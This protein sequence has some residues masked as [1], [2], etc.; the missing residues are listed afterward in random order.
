MPLGKSLF[1]GVVTTLPIGSDVSPD[2]DF[3]FCSCMEGVSSCQGWMADDSFLNG[4]NVGAHNNVIPK[5]V[6]NF[7]DNKIGRRRRSLSEE[8]LMTDDVD[9]EYDGRAFNYSSPEPRSRHNNTSGVTEED[10]RT[11]CWRVLWDESPVRDTCENLVSMRDVNGT[12]DKCI[13]DIRV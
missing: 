4:P 3:S 13:L 12:I 6:A 5:T 7:W 9:W 1:D 11:H 8:E 2:D 10:A